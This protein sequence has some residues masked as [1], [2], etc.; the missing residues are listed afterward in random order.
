MPWILYLQYALFLKHSE[1]ESDSWTK[2]KMPRVLVAINKTLLLVT[3]CSINFM[4]PKSNEKHV[5]LI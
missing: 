3:F 5:N 4:Q 1:F 2:I